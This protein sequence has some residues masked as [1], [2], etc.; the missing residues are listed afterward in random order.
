[1]TCVNLAGSFQREACAVLGFSSVKYD[2]Y[3]GFL[4]LE[5][6]KKNPLR[7]AAFTRWK[8]L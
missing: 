2:V 6:E 7:V 1:M 3:G 8:E 5:K 4:H